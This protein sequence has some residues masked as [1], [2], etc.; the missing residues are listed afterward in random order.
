MALAAG[1]HLADGRLIPDGTASNWSAPGLQHRKSVAAEMDVLNR[2]YRRLDRISTGNSSVL[3]AL[4]PSAM[5]CVC[6]V[7]PTT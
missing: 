6:N 7:D 3:T 1:W 5:Q 4:G 2:R